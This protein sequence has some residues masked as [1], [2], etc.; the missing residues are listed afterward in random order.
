VNARPPEEELAYHESGHAVVSAVL[1]F[2][3]DYVTIVQDGNAAGGSGHTGG[4]KMVKAPGIMDQMTV[5]YAGYAAHIKYEP[6]AE[7]RALAGA[8]DD[9]EKA[10]RSM[11][12]IR[13][14][15]IPGVLE[16]YRKEAARMVDENWSSI[17]RVA[18]A[19]V[20]E[21]TIDTERL[22]QLIAGES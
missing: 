13:G 18:Q 19:L 17:Q 11:L 8:R 4:Y 7:E 1:G 10:K 22:Q 16:H 6:D 15:P 5:S 14:Q 3:P 2:P 9:F 12:L 20:I 21:K